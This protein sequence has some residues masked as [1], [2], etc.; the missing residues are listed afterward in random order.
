ML[1]FYRPGHMSGN[2]TGREI[3][4]ILPDSV[5]EPPS[6]PSTW[7]DSALHCQHI[8]QQLEKLQLWQASAFHAGV[9]AEILIADRSDY[10]DN[11]LQRLWKFYGFDIIPDTSLIAVGG[12]GR[13]ELH[14]LSDIDILIL[15]KQLLSDEQAQKTGQLI[16]LL[17]DL[18]LEVG[19]SVRSLEDCL[20]KGLADL[21]IATSLIES[22]MV[23][24]DAVLFL[25]MQ[26]HIFNDNFWPSPAFF[27]A[28]ITE[29]H[30]RHQRYHGTSY[31]L[32]PDIKSSPGG[33]RDIHTL[34]WVARRHFG[35][36]SLHEMVD[37]GFLAEIERD[38]LDKCQS[39]LCRIRFALHLL[40]T[41]YDN[42]LLFDRQLNV[43]H[44]LCY[45]GEGNQAVEQMMKDFY[46]V[47]RH[48]SELNNMLL[49][50][51]NE[52][53]LTHDT[54]EK[55]RLLDDDFQLRA[56]LI[57]LRDE[58]LFMQQP[59]TIM[60]MFCLMVYHPDIKGI[61]STTVRQLRRARRLLKEPLCNIPA[62]RKQFMAILRHPGAAKHA[63]LP[64]HHHNIFSAYIPQWGKIVGQ[65]QFDLFHAWS[66]DEHT[67][68]VLQKLESFA[69]EATR[70]HH[71]L[72][73]ELYPRLPRPDLLMLA[74]L[75]HDIAKGR[76]GDHSILGAKDA[77]EFAL[78]HDL[79]SREAQMVAWL[80]RNH[81]LM[82]VTAQRRDIQDP[83]V[84][85]QFAAE[86]KSETHLHY[87][88]SLT[89]ADICA[90][91]E[92]LWNSWKQSLL[93]ELYF[94]TEKQLRRGMQNAPDLRDQVRHHRL[95]A[96]T[97]LRMDGIDEEALYHIWSR[98]RSD[99]FLRHAPN[100]LAW[101]ARHLL[102][103]NSTKPLVLI[104]RYATRGGTEIFICSADR[105]S[106]FA[107]VVTELNRRNLSVH[108]AQIF[109][110]R[111][112]MAMDTFIVLE[113]DGSPLAQDRHSVTRSA[114][115]QAIIQ[116]DYQHPNIPPLSTRLRHF[117][118]PTEV[119]F[120]AA[121]TDKRTY[122]ELITL[123]Q[124]GLL[125]RVSEIFAD[126]GLSLHS[127]RITTIGERAEDLFVLADK[128]RRALNVKTREELSQRLTDTLNS[129]DKL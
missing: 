81:L 47:T 44:S 21:T 98:C 97:L 4:L 60:R 6:L 57:D 108:D 33:L 112:G 1:A 123:D 68:R 69:D 26:Q 70:Q 35:A 14:P 122:L 46:R 96:L 113:P 87:L 9:T 118:V 10:I 89:V 67:I 65:M 94:A 49:Q 73:V 105:P 111:D 39:F 79:N 103:H 124:S 128:D 40:L 86:I 107:A 93:R 117:N 7:P 125:A 5:T 72:C 78:L 22:R 34:L 62:A 88:V 83:A 101:H 59:E 29:Q 56:G 95:Q 3:S 63:L 31:N 36:T 16:T 19:H 41:R 38:E 2:H 90:T 28:K 77:L 30:E 82:S 25:Q 106:L 120:L 13:R 115:E 15:S 51:F 52:A 53:I 17:W 55:P 74:A 84:I 71:P 37:F 66:V 50:L 127:A 24:G 91:N 126:M 104:S 64:M 18:K 85:G 119:K 92:T 75:F 8:K 76:G 99:Y 121:H 43:A 20:L 116:P 58:N 54:N 110:N 100:Q 12:Y 42:R 109:T 80:V 45:Q 32:E 61:Y 23:C 11:L 48:V 102:E 129:N 27:H 114:L